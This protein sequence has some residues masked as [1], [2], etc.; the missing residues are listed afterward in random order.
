MKLF[1]IAREGEKSALRL[2]ATVADCIRWLRDPLSHP[3]LDAMSERELADL[4][5]SSARIVGV[6]D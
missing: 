4:P 1:S 6:R 2:T 5:F 3:V